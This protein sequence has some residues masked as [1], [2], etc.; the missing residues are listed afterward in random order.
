MA[1]AMGPYYAAASWN[2]VAPSSVAANCPVIVTGEIVK[3][4]QLAVKAPDRF[5]GKT[6]RLLDIAHI[7]ISHVNKNLLTGVSTKIGRTITARMHP[8]RGRRAAGA[9][10]MTTSLDLHY[11][12]GTKALWMLYLQ[13]DGHF[14][15]NHRPEQRQPVGTYDKIKGRIDSVC[16]T[17]KP[18]PGE[19]PSQV[20]TVAEWIARRRKARL[21][22]DGAIQREK[23]ILTETQKVVNAL[24]TDGVLQPARL[25]TLIDQRAKVRSELA[26]MSARQMGISRDDWIVVR[27]YLARN[28]P[29]E[30][31]CIRALPGWIK[32]SKPA[33]KLLIESLGDKSAS[34]RLFACQAMM[35]ADDQTLSDKISPLLAD[36]NRRVRIVAV[37]TLGRL[38]DKRQAKA[39]EALYR[40]TDKM[41]AEETVMFGVA[42]ARLG[43][44]DT[45]MACFPKAMASPNWNIRWMAMGIIQTCQGPRIVP[46]IMAELPGELARASAEHRKHHIPDRVLRAMTAELTSRTDARYGMDIAAWMAWWSDIAHK[47]GAK[48]PTQAQIAKTEHIQ[49]DYYRLLKRSVTQ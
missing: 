31:H 1:I 33:H 23:A 8:P 11:T 28:D 3:I 44:L 49:T 2:A 24:Y 32:D 48:A 27:C 9:P 20:Y 29:V 30:N 41:I 35:N 39:I 43:R 12:T 18:K 15:I 47:H 36:P 10:I 26:N 4:E 5:D 22:N 7:R 34:M 37:R 13:D 40:K 38:G 25:G 21:A 45:P 17:K 14:Y 42:L 19:L 6:L 46:A 16:S